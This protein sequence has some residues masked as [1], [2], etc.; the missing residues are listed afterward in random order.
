MS[1]REQGIRQVIVP[2]ANI[3]EARLID[4]ID[5]IGVRHVGELIELMGGHA[6]YHI[7]DTQRDI[8][9]GMDVTQC[10]APG[11][12]CEVVGQ[13]STKW[14][15]EVAAAGGHRLQMARN[16]CHGKS[17]PRLHAKKRILA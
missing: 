16:P 11:D 1:A 10:S 6:T 12:M 13:E 7:P 14:A 15:L 9:T 2:H 8:G 3:D 5:V 4:D 17:L